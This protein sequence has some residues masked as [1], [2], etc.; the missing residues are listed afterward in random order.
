MAKL[1]SRSGPGSSAALAGAPTCPEFTIEASEFRTLLLDR[2][3]LPLAATACRCEGC[4]AAL[5]QHGIHLSACT[6]TGRLRKRAKPA[7]CAMLRVCREAG[8]LAQPEVQ[9]KDMNLGIP[10]GDQRRL[11][12]LAQGLPCYAGAQIAVDVTIRSSLSATGEVQGRADAEN[13]HIC[14]VAKRDKESKYPELISGGRCRLMVFALEVGGR[15]SGEAVDFIDQ[16]AWAR[17]RSA[18]QLVRFSAQL[19]WRRRWI[20]LLAV[21]AATAWAE[22]VTAPAGLETSCGPRDGNEPTLEAVLVDS[23]RN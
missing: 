5:D 7:E 10:A 23:C 15:F 4:G 20:R 14:T 12:V 8:A 22:S 1:R 17:S 6:K 3:H 2:M 11:D 13:E 18:P 16:L 21:A 19:A 9:L